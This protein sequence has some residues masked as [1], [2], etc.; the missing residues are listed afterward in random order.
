MTPYMM[1]RQLKNACNVNEDAL[2][3]LARSRVLLDNHASETKKRLCR[4]E[5]PPLLQIRA[6]E[7]RRLCQSSKQQIKAGAARLA[8]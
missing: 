6:T 1:Y 8:A 4:S 3:C 5:G 2:Q 7:E